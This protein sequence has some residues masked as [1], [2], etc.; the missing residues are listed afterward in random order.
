MAILITGASG[1]LGKSLKTLYPDALT[2]SH[3]ELD[4]RSEAN[5]LEYIKSN[6]PTTIFHSAA[7][8]GIRQCENDKKLAY[9]TNVIGTENLVKACMKSSPNCCLVYISTASV[10]AGDVGN[11]AEDD[12]PDPKNYYSL[13]KLLGEFA[14]RESSLKRWMVIRTNFVERAKWQY[15]KAFTDRFGT[16]LF[17]DDLALALKDVVDRGLQGILHVCGAEKMSMFDLAKITTPNV[18]PTTMSEYSGPPL[19][20]DMSLRSTRIQPYEISK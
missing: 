3:K 17:A 7:M 12:V 10:F 9:K 19:P 11:Y 20:T 4:I 18:K 14:I 1:K 2:P 8:T 15:E 5:V 6:A 16:Y 13:S